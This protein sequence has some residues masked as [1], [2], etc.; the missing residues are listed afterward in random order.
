MD[1]MSGD[2]DSFVRQIA[3]RRD[4]AAPFANKP[5]LAAADPEIFAGRMIALE[6]L[7]FREV[8]AGLSARY[9]MAKLAENRE[10]SGERAWAERL[11]A[12][13]LANA[14]ELE[15]FAKARISKTVEWTLGKELKELRGAE[16]L[17]S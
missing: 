10:L 4:G 11:E 15:P 1:V 5:V 7:A 9:D 12:A 2:P 8:L 3:Y 14:A 17:R 13:L 6:P 16:A